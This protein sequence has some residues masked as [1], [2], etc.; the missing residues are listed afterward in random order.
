M[1]KTKKAS[2]LISAII[3]RI[4]FYLRQRKIANGSFHT[5][6]F[7]ILLLSNHNRLIHL[8]YFLLFIFE[9]HSIFSSYIIIF[10]FSYH[11]NHRQYSLIHSSSITWYTLSHFLFSLLCFYIL[12]SINFFVYKFAIEINRDN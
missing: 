11:Q 10:R 9:P 3:P 2:T 1:T 4:L 6:H 12:L 7:P 8:F 5:Y